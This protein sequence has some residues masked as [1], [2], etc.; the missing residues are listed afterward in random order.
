[1]SMPWRGLRAVSLLFCTPSS[2]S[3]LSNKT[4]LQTVVQASMVERLDD[5][6]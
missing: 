2:K 6:N 5:L 1:M 4:Q 3:L